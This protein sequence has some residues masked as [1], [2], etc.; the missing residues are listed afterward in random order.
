MLKYTNIRV[1]LLEITYA[2][3]K[4]EIK[5]FTKKRNHSRNSEIVL[6]TIEEGDPSPAEISFDNNDTSSSASIAASLASVVA[7]TPFNNDAVP[8]DNDASSLAPVVTPADN[9]MGVAIAAC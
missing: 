3:L 1:G 7:E 6:L 4:N 8:F 2:D 9:N 5:R